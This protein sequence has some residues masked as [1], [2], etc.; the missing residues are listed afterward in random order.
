M[1]K[2]EFEG[3]TYFYSKKNRK[4]YDEHYIELSKNEN[5]K[6][7]E[8]YFSN[9][10]N[11][12]DMTPEEILELA[13]ELRENWFAGSAIK[14][15]E[16]YM[17]D[18]RPGLEFIK[19]AM[20]TLLSCYRKIGKSQKAIDIGEDYLHKGG[21]PTPAFL[22]S[23]AAACCDEGYYD[24]AKKYADMAFAMQGGSKGYNTELSLVYA[25]IRKDTGI[26]Y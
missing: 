3:N 20:S 25:R 16:K 6:V 10:I 7:A 22:T 8:Y 14:L 2:F 18:V 1:E 24:K 4:F 13:R 11:V 23:L 17:A 9:I 26:I 15:L 5:D 19:Y 12:E 21:Q